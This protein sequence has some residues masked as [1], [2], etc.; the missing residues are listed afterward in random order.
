MSNIEAQKEV[1]TAHK[2]SVDIGRKNVKSF[3]VH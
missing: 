3:F 2:T 1:S